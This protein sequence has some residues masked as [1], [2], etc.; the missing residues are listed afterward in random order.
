VEIGARSKEREYAYPRDWYAAVIDAAASGSALDVAS[1]YA[2]TFRPLAMPSTDGAS[3]L[4]DGSLEYTFAR[5]PRAEEYEDRPTQRRTLMLAPD[6]GGWFVRDR[7]GRIVRDRREVA[8]LLSGWPDV[9][10]FALSLLPEPAPGGRKRCAPWTIARALLFADLQ[11]ALGTCATARRL[12]AWEDQ[13]GAPWHIPGVAHL[14][15]RFEAGGALGAEERRTLKRAERT[16]IRSCRRA[17]V[18]PIR[19]C[20]D[21]RIRV[22]SAAARSRGCGSVVRWP[23]HPRSAHG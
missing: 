13:L 3:R 5:L 15:S 16:M 1:S 7:D 21:T 19:D 20:L 4:P 23:P 22:T 6:S 2:A 10:R 9:R 11:P 12:L 18:E 8:R 17:G 14:V